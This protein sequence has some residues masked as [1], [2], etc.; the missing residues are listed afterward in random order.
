MP[1]TPASFSPEAGY[2]IYDIRSVVGSCFLLIDRSRREVVLI[3][4]GLAGEKPQFEQAL[5][6]EGLAWKELKVILLTHGHLDHTGNLSWIKKLTGVPVRAHP[7]E[8]AHIDGTFHYHGPSR[9]CGLMQRAGRT[10]LRYQPVKIN[11]ALVPGADL[12]FW[13]GLK[14]LHLP[15]HTEGHC[16]FYSQRFDLLFS[17]DLFASYSFGARLPPFPFNSCPEKIKGSLR[18]VQHLAPRHLIANH[19]DRLD[20]ELHRR[21]F[22]EL[23]QRLN[24]PV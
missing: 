11:E 2:A 1:A 5:A 10:L 20:G 16:G 8:Q 7:L 12:P 14:V 19:A 15:G 17:G 18:T 22:D 9:A 21:R 24:P 6:A 4:A 3:D 13:G 23:V